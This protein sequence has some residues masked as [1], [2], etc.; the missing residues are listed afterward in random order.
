MTE[1]NKQ[2]FT[3][4]VL[5]VGFLISSQLIIGM[6]IL[7]VRSGGAFDLHMNAN[8]YWA[9]SNYIAALL[10]LPILWL[11]D[12]IEN[13]NTRTRTSI[14]IFFLCFLALILTVSRGGILTI[15]LSMVLY[16]ILRGKRLS[17]TFI[18]LIAFSIIYIFLTKSIMHRFLH[19]VDQGNI[20]RIYLWLQSIELISKEPLLGYG[21]GNLM[22]WANFFDS[23]RKMPGP[24]NIILEIMLHIG[25]GGF[26][27]CAL[28]TFMLLRKAVSFYKIEKNPIYIVLV[29]ASLAHSMVE[30]TFMGYQY[31]FIFW[32]FMSFLMLELKV[33]QRV[34]E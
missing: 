26:L 27:L 14:I 4:G 16:T 15:V 21:P 18:L 31:G 28:L 19:M 23:V 33:P 30:P 5:I 11:Y 29:F 20:S 17:K 22:L 12:R 24:H 1:V 32:Y 2:S 8:L 3:N 7:Y 10:E 13:K 25:I 34:R 6:I 9:K